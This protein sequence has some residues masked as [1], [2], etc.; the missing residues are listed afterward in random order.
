M[1]TDI[2]TH[3]HN[4]KDA[5][6]NISPIDFKPI[7]GLYYSLG[8]HPWH[9]DVNT[10]ETAFKTIETLVEYYPQIVAIGE[11]GLDSLIKVPHETQIKVF[12]QHIAIS[13]QQK[14]PLII[15]CVRSSNELL[16]IYRK[17]KPQMTWI[18]HGF[19]SNVNVL[20][21]FLD[22]PNIY[23]SIGE[24]FNTETVKAIPNERLLI[25]TDESLLSIEEIA[26][27]IAKV[28]NFSAQNILDITTQNNKTALSLK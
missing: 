25:E 26:E 24:N 13:E 22:F 21:S 19:R 11:C 2:H 27:Q 16:H 3:C 8:I 9:I 5:V 6:I 15:H 18:I 12:E 17:H 23:I 7:D 14:K 1:I 10:V 28:R 20:R 4:R